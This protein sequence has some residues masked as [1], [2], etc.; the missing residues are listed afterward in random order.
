MG[1]LKKVNYYRA[2]VASPVEDGTPRD[3]MGHLRL[4]YNTIP[5]KLH[6][7]LSPRVVTRLLFKK[8]CPSAS[9]FIN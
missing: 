4:S 7:D 1:S 5:G 3:K 9:G 8:W 6:V 2:Y